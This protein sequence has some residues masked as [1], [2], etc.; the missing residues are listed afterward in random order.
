[1]Q[2][3]VSAIEHYGLWLVFFNV[4]ALQL[5][6]P[7]P[8]YPT[9]ILM[10]AIAAAGEV[11]VA[12]VVWVAVVGS[13]V[14][15]L[16]WY[17]AGSR[18]GRRMLRLICKV[19]LS[20]DSC[21]RQTEDIYQRWGPASLMV[22][23]FIPGFAAVATSMAGATRSRLSSF[24]FFDAIGALLWSGVAVALGWFFRDA[25]QQVVAALEQAGR[26]GVLFLGVA[27]ASYLAVKTLQRYRLIRTLRMARI[28]V[29]ELNEM[30]GQGLRP[31]VVDVRSPASQAQGRIP[32]A[33]WIDHHAFDQSLQA[34][35]LDQRAAEEVIVYCAC[36]NEASAAEVAK[37]L[38]RAGFTRV[39]PLAGG[40][41]AWAD[42]GYALEPGSEALDAR[43]R[44]DALH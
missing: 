7:L 3:L 10:G 21:V 40:I 39:R 20:P 26:W 34:Q 32:G 25:V 19:S 5:G 28:T 31:L 38:M 35:Q 24:V 43:G 44:T 12:Q 13:L 29:D 36:P 8:A 22:A 30:L 23:K 15:D 37:K 33:I 2:T 27:L 9:L 1:M 41:E 42:R 14:A 4:L 11:S 16:A 6:L 17:A 18:H